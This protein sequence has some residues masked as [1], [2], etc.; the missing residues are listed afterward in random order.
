MRLSQQKI[1]QGFV[2]A[3]LVNL[4]VL[5]FSR[6]FTNSAIPE[7][8]P[9]VMSNFGLVMI[10]LWGLAYISVAKSYTKVNYLVA[11]FALEKLV[12]GIVWLKW[13]IEHDIS[14]VYERDLF[15]GLF[16]SSYGLNDFL[17]FGFFLIVFIRGFKK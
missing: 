13:I 5:I 4:S 2:L 6:F 12:Y 14:A 7:T 9:A 1:T 3:G 8:D 17:F 16:Y 11:V 10:V 15:A